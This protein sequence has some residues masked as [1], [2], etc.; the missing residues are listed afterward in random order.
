MYS[1]G[2]PRPLTLTDTL[3]DHHV[4]SRVGAVCDACGHAAPVD[5]WSL[6]VRLGWE[7]PLK[8]V[9]AKLRCTRCSAKRCRLVTN[10]RRSSR[11]RS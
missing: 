6:G 3:A 1:I 5:T 8:D 4:L 7:T 11:D 2:M 10:L 9:E